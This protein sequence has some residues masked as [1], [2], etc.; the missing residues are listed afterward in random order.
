MSYIEKSV[1][2]IIGECIDDTEE[3][4]EASSS[5]TET[6]EAPVKAKKPRSQKQ[7]ESLQKARE[8]RAKSLALKREQKKTT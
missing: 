2:D 8:A 5:V 4:N 3:H 1:E 6:I 7:I